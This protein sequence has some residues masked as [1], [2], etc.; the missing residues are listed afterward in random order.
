MVDGIGRG[1]GRVHQTG[2]ADEIQ[3]LQE[4]RRPRIEVFD[5][6]DTLTKGGPGLTVGSQS[7]L[8]QDQQDSINNLMS[9]MSP[10]QQTAFVAAGKDFSSQLLGAVQGGQQAG[11]GTLLDICRHGAQSAQGLTGADNAAD[12]ANNAMLMAY[13]GSDADLMVLAKKVNDAN[14]EKGAIRN[15]E[16]TLREESQ[17]LGEQ[18]DKWPN[19]GSKQEVTW[20]E[21][22][23]DANGNPVKDEKGNYVFEEKTAVM[24]KEE[25]TALKGKVDGT[26]EKFDQKLQTL[27]DMN[28]MDMLNLQ[29]AMNKQSQLMNLLTNLSKQMH[30]IAMS[31][32][33]NLK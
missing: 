22:K 33:R 4:L 14:Q 1:V 2:E 27:T 31:I 21:M 28:Q 13:K 5:Q 9:G 10:E 23:L 12:V 32:L 3:Q 29:E 17:M 16:T 7:T 25:A 19:D 6:N 20:R 30:E 26:I 18:I 24:T 15:A 11:E 8:P